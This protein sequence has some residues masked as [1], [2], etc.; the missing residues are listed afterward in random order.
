VP[1]SRAFVVSAFCI[2][3]FPE[4]PAASAMTSSRARELAAELVLDRG[5]TLM[6]RLGF[7]VFLEVSE[8]ASYKKMRILTHPDKCSPERKARA[9]EAFKQL[10][11]L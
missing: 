5:L 8:Q 11:N 1:S 7:R 6:A 2:S 3:R 10:D 9:E 4:A